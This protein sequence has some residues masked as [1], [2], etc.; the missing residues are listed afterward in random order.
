MLGEVSFHKG[1]ISFSPATEEHSPRTTS[2]N[3]MDHL[4]RGKL[5][6]QGPDSSFGEVHRV[7]YPDDVHMEEERRKRVEVKV[8]TEIGETHRKRTK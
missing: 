7:S 5:L 8:Q 2:F 1:L 6:A 4:V 3:I